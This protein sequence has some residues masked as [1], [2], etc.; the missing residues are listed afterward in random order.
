MTPSFNS[1]FNEDF[2]RKLEYT[3]CTLFAN[4]EDEELRRFWCDGI[5]WAPYYNEDVNRDYLSYEKVKERG[6]I[7]TSGRMGISGQDRY[8]VKIVL[9]T[10]ALKHY[11]KGDSLI[12]CLPSSEDQDWIEI[13]PENYTI[14]I[15]LL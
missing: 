14:E 9:G 8:E 6:F 3:L 2:C 11:Q 10:K 7:E 15:Q 13:D 12:P 4:C 5:S 1:S